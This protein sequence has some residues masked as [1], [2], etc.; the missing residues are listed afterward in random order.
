[1]QK[2]FRAGIGTLKRLAS[3]RKLYVEALNPYFGYFYTVKKTLLK[4]RTGFQDLRLLDTD[5]FGKVLLIDNITQVAD[6]NDWHHPGPASVLIIGGGDGGILREVLKYPCVKNVDLAELDDGVIAFSKKH[7][8]TVHRGA[9]RDPRVHIHVTDGRRFIEERPGRYDIVVMDMTDPSGP[10]TLLYTK[11]FF[12]IVKHAFKNKNGIFVMHSESP[13]SRPGAFAC[14]QKTLRVV[15]P[16]VTPF[17]V[18]IQMYGVL[19]SVTLSSPLPRQVRARAEQIDARLMRYGIRG[20]R[21]YSGATHRSMQTPYP[22]ITAL[23]KRPARTISDADPAFPDDFLL[24]N[25][26]RK[27]VTS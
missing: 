23:L 22:Y 2:Y 10:S 5:E 11:E 27:R 25:K 12:G 16:S 14:I 4:A 13:V 21:V 6:R 1:M 20:L 24:S 26:V 9:F 18:Y 8:P 7:L 3:G 15:F 17:Y 19:W